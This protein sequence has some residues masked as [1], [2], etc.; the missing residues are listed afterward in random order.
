MLPWTLNA[1]H[2]NLLKEFHLERQVRGFNREQ[3]DASA[4]L[5]EEYLHFLE[6]TCQTN[7]L[8]ADKSHYRKFLKHL[9][10]RKKF[11]GSG[12][13]SLSHTRQIRYAIA[14]LYDFLSNT[15]RVDVD[16]SMRKLFYP[17]KP[18]PKKIVSCKMVKLIQSACKNSTEKVIV[19][20]AYGCGLRR[21]EICRLNLDDFDSIGSTITVRAG[22]NFKM[23]IVPVADSMRELIV[24]HYNSRLCGATSIHGNYPFI[25]GSKGH[26]VGGN[27][28]YATFRRTLY[29]ARKQ[30]K[31]V[32]LITLHQLR[33][34]V[35][36]H[37]LNAGADIE[38]VQ[39]FLG[40]SVID[41][42]SLYV[43]RRRMRFSIRRRIAA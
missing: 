15:G 37:L 34:S 30:N 9:G 5:C 32:P 22:K 1:L 31:L 35:A 43:K 12:M 20:F 27:V 36:V 33:N 4:R 11:R 28:L 24:A 16:M 23:R 19:A 40:H 29:R 41:T 25:V 3:G 2:E 8:Q 6:H 42:T 17:F 10:S 21:S 13:V 18:T 38:F 26:R 39:R 14:S 7:V